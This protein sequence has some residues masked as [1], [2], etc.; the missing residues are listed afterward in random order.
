MGILSNA[1]SIV[2]GANFGDRLKSR[3]PVQNIT[4]LGISVMLISLV[5]MLENVFTVSEHNIKSSD[6][7]IVVLALLAGSLIGE[8]LKI[9]KIFISTRKQETRE[10]A[11]YI[12][13]MFFAVGGLQITGPLMLSLNNDGSQL[14]IKSL[15]DFPFA[16]AL[17]AAYGKKVAFSAFPVAIMQFGIYATAFL[18]EKYLV[19]GIVEQ[20]CA[21]G[22]II[23]FFT[24]FNLV[25]D[26]KYKINTTN[27]LPA[28][29]VVIIFN[30]VVR[31][32][33]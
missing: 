7:I 5:G 12:G 29:I 24:G 28:I 2:L 8:A 32:W 4:I 1:I 21:I 17:G 27:M 16:F 18:L 10:N 13:T 19:N 25:C 22:Y 26:K 14:F 15:I 3:I 23:L 6:L 31:I 30:C 9:D 20:I 11:F 33:R